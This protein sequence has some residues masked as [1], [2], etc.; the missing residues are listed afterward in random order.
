MCKKPLTCTVV[1]GIEHGEKS[2]NGEDVSIFGE[3]HLG[4]LMDDGQRTVQIDG[5]L[6]TKQTG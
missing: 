3:H 6:N 2:A 5:K 1:V 4:G